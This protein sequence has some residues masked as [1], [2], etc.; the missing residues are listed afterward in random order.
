MSKGVNQI[1]ETYG[2]PLPVKVSEVLAQSKGML[3]SARILCWFKLKCYHR[4]KLK[5]TYVVIMKTHFS[6][7]SL[8]SLS[9]VL[10][11]CLYSRWSG[12]RWSLWGWLGMA[13]FWSEAY[14]MGLHP[15]THWK[16]TFYAANFASAKT[17]NGV[18]VTLYCHSLLPLPDNIIHTK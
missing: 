15:Y 11:I 7:S 18:C 1:V 17:N 6:A 13:C 9:P 2:S 10:Q 5:P 4:V 8:W 12:K 16:G 14:C 3:G